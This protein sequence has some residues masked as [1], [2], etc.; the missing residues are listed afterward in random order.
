MRS[1]SASR[2]FSI[3]ILPNLSE[4]HD[5]YTKKFSK[6]ENNFEVKNYTTEFTNA[7]TPTSWFYNMYVQSQNETDS[8][9]PPS[10][11]IAFFLDS[12][13]SVLE[14]NISTNMIITQLF[15]VCFH[16]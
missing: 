2:R 16:D 13:A 5:H 4:N 15:N 6:W 7:I 8:K 1:A 10:L 11:E 9:S 12:G 3:I 14:I